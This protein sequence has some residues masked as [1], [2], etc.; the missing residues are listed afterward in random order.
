[1]RPP[2]RNRLVQICFMFFAVVIDNSL[3]ERGRRQPHGLVRV[4]R[5]R[6]S[7]HFDTLK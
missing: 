1:M 7:I 4:Q 2:Y 5:Y 6:I 3:L